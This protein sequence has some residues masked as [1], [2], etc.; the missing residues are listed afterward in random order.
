MWILISCVPLA[1]KSRR[2][3]F[4]EERGEVDGITSEF[5]RNVKRGPSPKPKRKAKLS[6]TDSYNTDSGDMN[7][8]VVGDN[9]SDSTS[10]LELEDGE[11][12]EE[13]DDSNEEMEKYYSM[14]SYRGALLAS[15]RIVVQWI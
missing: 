11:Q 5:V 9:Q 3:L 8:A 12:A 15:D 2:L 6:T 7:V 13:E 4:L 1:I 10:V 14:F